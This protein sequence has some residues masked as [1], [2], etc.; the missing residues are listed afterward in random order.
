MP[1]AVK[2]VDEIKAEL[3]TL[4]AKKEAEK[5]EKEGRKEK[6]DWYGLIYCDSNGYASII[7]DDPEGIW[8]GKTNEII[9]YLK[10][11][12]I[13]GENI[14]M[15]LEA[16]RRF[17]SE[18]ENPSCHLATEND[19]TSVITPES[20]PNRATFKKDPQF[21]GFLEQLI[22]KGYGLPTIQR[23]LKVKG[24]D[25]PYRTLGRWVKKHRDIRGGSHQTRPNF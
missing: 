5:K 7:G 1:V 9:P 8:L 23:E 12:Q 11:E 4:R 21:L 10:K 15:V 22:A 2:H 20:N 3:D 17:R 6:K 24:F 19:T 14:D 25:V 18:Q 13:D 16:V